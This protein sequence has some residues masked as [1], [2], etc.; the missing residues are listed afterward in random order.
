MAIDPKVEAVATPYRAPSGISAVNTPAAMV[1]EL[2]RLQ[3][4]I[5][6]LVELVPQVADRAPESPRTG[7]IRKALG[8]YW[9]PLTLATDYWVQWDGANWVAFP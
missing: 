5:S 6:E 7:T 8:T 2:L 3:T 4:T 9:D 1:S